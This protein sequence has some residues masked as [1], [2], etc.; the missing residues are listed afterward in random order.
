MSYARNTSHS[1][2]SRVERRSTSFSDQSRWKCRFSEGF[3]SVKY[4]AAVKQVVILL[5]VLRSIHANLALDVLCY[6]AAET[7]DGN[8]PK[9]KI[10][11][12]PSCMWL[13]WLLL[14]IPS[15]LE[16][17]EAVCTGLLF[18][19]LVSSILMLCALYL[20]QLEH[21]LM[22]SSPRWLKVAITLPSVLVELL[23]FMLLCYATVSG[24]WHWNKFNVSKSATVLAIVYAVILLGFIILQT[25][26]H[27]CAVFYI[28][29]GVNMVK[30]I[31]SRPVDYGFNIS[32]GDSPTSAVLAMLK[33]QAE[34]ER[35]PLMTDVSSVYPLSSAE[36]SARRKSTLASFDLSPTNNNDSSLIRL[37]TSPDKSIPVDSPPYARLRPPAVFHFAN[38]PFHDPDDSPPLPKIREHLNRTTHS[39]YNKVDS[40]GKF[41]VSNVIGGERHPSTSLDE[42]SYPE[43]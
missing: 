11:L 40:S 38:T 41:K 13:H 16:L 15:W 34:T 3:L 27:I 18:F 29:R 24:A 28:C 35:A 22:L 43:V 1:S 23:F 12:R 33:Y 8:V 2:P 32:T 39:D 9:V 7:K 20:C 6:D 25:I 26:M 37:K 4:F 21:S 30:P 10:C 42:Y 36:N 31:S 5:Y 17:P 19:V 14:R